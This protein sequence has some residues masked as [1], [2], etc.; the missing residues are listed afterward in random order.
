MKAEKGKADKK[1]KSQ[2]ELDQEF[3]KRLEELKKRDPFVYK[4]F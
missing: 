3:K 1:Q 2:K 4:S